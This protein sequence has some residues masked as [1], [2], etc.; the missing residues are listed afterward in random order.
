MEGLYLVGSGQ[1]RSNWSNFME[2]EGKWRDLVANEPRQ[3]GERREGQYG[4]SQGF[5]GVRGSDKGKGIAREKQGLHKQEG[6]YHPY[7]E[8]FSRGYG[9]GPSFYGR[10]S[11]YG[12]K[13]KAFQTKDSQ[14]QQWQGAGEQRPLN[15]TK[16][17]LDAFKGV[18]GS[19]GSGGVKGIG[20][21]GNASSSKA[22][23][24]LSFDEAVPEVQ[25]EKMDQMEAVLTDTLEVQEQGELVAETKAE[26]EQSLHSE[27]L[28]EANLMIDGVILSDSELQL[29]GDDLEDWEQGEIMDFAEEDG[30]AV[31][32]QD[33]GMLVLGDQELGDQALGDHNLGVQEQNDPVDEVTGKV[34][35]NKSGEEPNDEK[36]SKKKEM[37]QEAATAGGAKKRVGLAFAS[38]RKKLLAKVAAKQGDK[39]RKGPPKA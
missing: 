18:T 19:H 3:N 31:G 22:R 7:K 6:V 17:M 25:S 16:L 14:Q 34:P 26:T 32:D 23:K 39:A 27:A 4:R 5:Q 1:F 21:I 11:G 30:L 36:A 35:E 20:T 12:N 8:K 15:P 24:S 2:K 13:K 38:P 10:N 37:K 9:E 28:D 29:E 33:L